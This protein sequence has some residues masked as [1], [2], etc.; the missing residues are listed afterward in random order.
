MKELAATALLSGL[1][2]VVIWAALRVPIVEWSWTTRECVQ[3]L[4]SEAGNCEQLPGRYTR[5][6]VR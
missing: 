2:C 3:V 1:F 4:P 5:V 6:W